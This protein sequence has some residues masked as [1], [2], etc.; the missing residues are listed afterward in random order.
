MAVQIIGHWNCRDCAL[1]RPAKP[2]FSRPVAKVTA[3]PIPTP[4]I[5]PK[6]MRSTT[7]ISWYTSVPAGRMCSGSRRTSP[8]SR[9]SGP[10]LGIPP[11]SRRTGAS[12]SSG[13]SKG[14]LARTPFRSRLSNYS[15]FKLF[16][17]LSTL[18]GKHL[19]SIQFRAPFWM[20][21]E[22]GFKSTDL[23]SCTIFKTIF[24]RCFFLY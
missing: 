4:A 24:S 21:L 19:V 6:I 16:F 5:A 1:S 15:H 3:R 12:S 23:N 8:G 14:N 20:Q 11:D 2:S 10:C 7:C 22:T 17:P 13:G 18:R 9:I